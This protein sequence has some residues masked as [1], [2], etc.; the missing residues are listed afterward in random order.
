MKYVRFLEDNGNEG[1]GILK[2]EVIEVLDGT[3]F[4]KYE[5]TS[6]CIE[7]EKVKL[8]SPSLFSKAVCIGLNYGITLR[9]SD[10]QYLK[11]LSYF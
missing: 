5:I 7:K 2:D 8:L 9:S 6:R 1:Y 10:F 4:D 11:V 3:P